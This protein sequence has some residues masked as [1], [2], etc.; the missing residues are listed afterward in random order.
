MTATAATS[1]PSSAKPSSGLSSRQLLIVVIGDFWHGCTTPIPSAALVAVLAEFDVSA[2]NARAALSR[3]SRRGTLQVRKEGRRTFYTVTEETAAW[4]AER[5]RLLMRF[6][7][8]WP[9][10]D[11]R[12][13]FVAFSLPDDV[14]RSGPVLRT[15]LRR[16]GMAQLY[17]GLWVSPH[18]MTDGLT[19]LLSDQGVVASTIVRAD[20]APQPARRRDPADAWDLSSLRRDYRRWTAKLER[21]ADRLGAGRIGPAEALIARTS[22]TVAWRK[23]VYDDP[24]LPRELLPADWPIADAREAF[25]KVYD[26][27]G[28]LAQAR[29]REVV[30]PF[31]LAPDA[32]PRFHTVADGM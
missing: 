6:G 25:I 7:L 19:S 23:F 15:A 10:W 26:G 29:A 3:L 11:G 24:R 4:A 8:D 20:V 30:A 27:L 16:L 14:N 28:P 2:T 17:D 13:T 18:D 32:Q 1:S 12:W 22:V 9:A 31:D 5:G 21:L